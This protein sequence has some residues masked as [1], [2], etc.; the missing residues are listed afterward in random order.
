MYPGIADRMQK[1]LTSLSPASMKVGFRIL[2]VNRNSR[3]PLRRLKSLLLQRGSILCGS[4]VL[5]LVCWPSLSCGFICGLCHFVSQLLSAL[6]RI[7]GCP[8][9]SMTSL[10]LVLFIAVCLKCSF[11][12][13]SLIL[14][15]LRVFLSLEGMLAGTS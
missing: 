12:T 8:S 9:R 7:S 13:N 11:M 15:S 6:S 3:G 2:L 1:E 4:V 5:S 14:S 10:A